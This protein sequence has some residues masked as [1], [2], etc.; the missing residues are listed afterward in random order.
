VLGV[1][2]GYRPVENAAFAVE[3]GRVDLFERKLDVV[4]RLLAGEEVTAAGDGFRLERARLALVPERPPP[5]WLA[6]NSDVAVRR[7]ARLADAWLVNPHTRLDELERQMRLFRSERAAGGRP[8]VAQT[9]ILKEVC[10][11]ASDEEAMAVARPHLGEKYR[12]YV[13]WGQS[14]VLPPTDSLRREWAE[15]TAGGRFIIGSPPTCAAIVR[16]HVERLGVDHLIGRFQWPGMPQQHVLRSMRLLAEEVLPA[17]TEGRAGGA[18][19]VGG[20]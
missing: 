6:A 18:R 14:E 5:V 11:A 9:P 1:G 15:L 10:V 4:R 2:F 8:P 20:G 12:A 13:D 17:V 3:R 19:P 7:A 16:E